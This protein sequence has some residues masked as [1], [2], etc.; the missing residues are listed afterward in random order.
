MAEGV[1]WTRACR[2]V[3]M[4][5]IDRAKL[6]ALWPMEDM[7]ACDEGMDLASIFLER[8]FEAVSVLDEAEALQKRNQMI[9]AH[10]DLTAHKASCPKCNEI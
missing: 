10:K 1:V 3:F 4:P 7:P 8:C 6:L 9:R 5:S 2:L